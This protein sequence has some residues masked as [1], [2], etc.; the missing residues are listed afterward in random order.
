MLVV[1]DK[2]VVS[3]AGADLL[4]TITR[5]L[6]TL[7]T[8]MAMGLEITHLGDLK[9]SSIISWCTCTANVDFFLSSPNPENKENH[10]IENL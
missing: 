3:V 5:N 9:V 10:L 8:T 7:A 1:Y 2:A 4:E 6:E